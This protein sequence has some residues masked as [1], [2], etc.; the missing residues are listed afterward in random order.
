MLSV[1]FGLGVVLLS[2]ISRIPGGHRAGLEAFI[3]GKTA[4]MTRGDL[5]LIIYL[6]LGTLALVVVL[7]KEFK[8]TTFDQAF[9]Q[10]FYS[11]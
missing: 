10:D 1:F 9:A 4:G 3:L 5:E 2:V 8:L 6:A 7:Y 11:T